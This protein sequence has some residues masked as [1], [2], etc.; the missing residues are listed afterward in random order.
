MQNAL[1]QRFFL[2][3]LIAGCAAS[4][5]Q[6]AFEVASIRSHGPEVRVV[7]LSISGPRVTVEAFALANL[8]TYAYD[9]KPYQVIGGPDWAAIERFDLAAKAEGDATVSKEQVREML[10]TLVA[11]RFKVQLHRAMREMPVYALVIAKGGP[12]LAPSPTDAKPLM[13]L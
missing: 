1:I 13:I 11:D 6:P 10:K 7:G 5:Q 12:K 9:L 3:G 8:I 2:F 4:G